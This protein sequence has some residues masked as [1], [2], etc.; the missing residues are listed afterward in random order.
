[1]T[2]IEHTADQ[3]LSSSQERRFQEASSAKCV[4]GAF[5]ECELQ[6]GEPLDPSIGTGCLGNLTMETERTSDDNP[7]TSTASASTRSARPL[8]TQRLRS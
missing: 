8:P 6:Y 7:I 1:V 3:S 2:R 4:K 5:S